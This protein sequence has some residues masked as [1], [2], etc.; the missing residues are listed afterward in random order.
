METFLT[1]AYIFPLIIGL[2]YVN[3]LRQ[4]DKYRFWMGDNLVPKVM[5]YTIL[6]FLP[7][8]NILLLIYIFTFDTNE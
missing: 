6:S 4:M 8:I 2:A 5:L 3:Y 7:A 1:L